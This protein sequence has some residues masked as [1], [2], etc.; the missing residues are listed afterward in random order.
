MASPPDRLAALLTDGS[1]H[2]DRLLAVVASVDP[3]PPTEDGVVS[4]LDRLAAGLV[5]EGAPDRVLAHVYGE[6]GFVGNARRYY[7]PHNSMIH[8][9]LAGRRGIPL[10]LA[11]VVVEIGRR[12]DVALSVVGLPGHVVIG[13]GDAPARWFDPFAGGA[14]LDAEACRRIF[15]RFHPAEAFD[16]QMLQPIDPVATVTRTLNNL[17]VAY[18]RTGDLSQLVKV[19]ALAVAVPGSPVTERHE[20]AATLA[21]VGRDEQAAEQRDLLATLDPPR[22]EAHLRAARRH[23]ARRN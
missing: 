4:E 21:A 12:V 20:L 18:R 13:D 23:R 2:L 7:S 14:E 11:A 10:S 19:Q 17:K 9:V 15:A 5:G 16:E 6:L 8:R 3:E 1:R 22:R